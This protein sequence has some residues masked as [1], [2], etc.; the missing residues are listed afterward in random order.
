MAKLKLSI[1]NY[2]IIIA[3]VLF[4]ISFWLW[5]LPLQSSHVPFG[6]GDAAWQFAAADQMYNADHADYSIPYYLG[7]WYYG[8]NKILGP[9]TNEYPPPYSVNISLA[10]LFGGGRFLSAYLMFAVLCMLASL[11]TFLLIRKLYGILP[12]FLAGF[13]MVFSM[14]DIMTYLWGQRGSVISF[15]FI[16]IAI[17]SFYMFLTSPENDKKKK[18]YLFSTIF[19]VASQY[20][21][22]IQGAVISIASMGIFFLLMWL[23]QKK[24]PFNFKSLKTSWKPYA[25]A[26]FVFL[27]LITPFLII[28]LG[29]QETHPIKFNNVDRLFSW[30][31]V[32]DQPG[33][34]QGNVEGYPLIYFTFSSIYSYWYLPLLI[35]G[36]IIILIK[37]ESRDLLMLA[38]L[39]A[40]YIFIHL[41]VTGYLNLQR[42]ARMLLAETALFYSLI[43]IGIVGAASFFGSGKNLRQISKYIKYSLAIAFVAVFIFSNAKAAYG[44]L[45]GAYSPILRLNPYQLEVSDWISSN[46][47]KDAMII[48]KGTITYPKIRFMLAVSQRHVGNQIQSHINSNLVRTDQIYYMVDY[49]DLALLGRQDAAQSL[50]EWEK[51]TFANSTLIYN[52]NNIH[53]WYGNITVFTN[54]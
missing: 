18:V 32:S 50:F 4:L 49:S 17:Y 35:L 41:D 10:Q 48:S 42:A 2:E 21:F 53:I 23:K 33:Y 22:H 52:K 5:T 43:S 36:I 44:V 45:N 40:I 51:S 39:I 7:M 6:E 26:V 28:Y 9:N 47:P 46:L 8:Y 30:F 11:S 37:R 1:K 25:I 13:A 54:E 31:K 20:M 27:A 29:P 34:S 12:G 14:R 3:V 16:P 19:I 15:T 24:F 38:W